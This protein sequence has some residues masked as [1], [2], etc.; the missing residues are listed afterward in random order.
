MAGSDRFVAR[1]AP[2]F[3]SS[4][5]F[6]TERVGAC[7]IYCSDGRYNEQFDEFLHAHL[8]LPRYDRLV[9]PGGPAV[10]AGHLVAHRDEAAIVDQVSFLV[11][12][13]ALERAVLIAHCSCGFYRSR[14]SVADHRV[15]AAEERDLIV[16]AKRLRA[17]APSLAIQGYVAVVADSR[18]AFE[19][20]SLDG[21][22][23]AW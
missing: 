7:A 3:R 11:R 8:G 23:S 12:A 1:V 21:C 5:P 20:V 4:L 13:H 17:I 10:L 9:V 22:P 14:L 15:R 2:V 6:E 19:E 16:G 18:V